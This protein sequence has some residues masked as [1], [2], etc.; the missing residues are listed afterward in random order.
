MTLNKRRTERYFNQRV[1][2]R[3]FK[4]G[5]LS[6][7]ENRITMQEEGKL[8]PYWEGP[9]VVITNNQPGS[10]FLKDAQGKELPHLWN[11]EHIK[12]YYP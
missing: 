1:K 12:R 2:P 10:Y 8:G 11:S 6:L 4:I 7:R 5:D 9:Y 3:T